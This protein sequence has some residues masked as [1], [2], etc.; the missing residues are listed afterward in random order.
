MTITIQQKRFLYDDSDWSDAELRQLLAKSSGE[1]GWNEPE[2]DDY[3]N[4]DDQIQKR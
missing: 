4:Y 1:N 3:D 2:M